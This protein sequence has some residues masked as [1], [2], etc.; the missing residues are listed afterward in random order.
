MI[1]PIVLHHNMQHLHHTHLL[2]F[3]DQVGKHPLHQKTSKSTFQIQV[4]S[5]YFIC[6]DIFEKKSSNK[7]S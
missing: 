3:I 1:L 6:L 5:I 4:F 2:Q 7:K